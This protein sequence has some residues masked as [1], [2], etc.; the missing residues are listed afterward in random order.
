[1]SL[2]E[3]DY[4]K[5]NFITPQ[6][7]NELKALINIE[8]IGKNRREQDFIITND[9]SKNTLITAE[10]MENLIQALN[11]INNKFEHIIKNETLITAWK[12]LFQW[13]ESL[14]IL[15]PIK[16]EHKYDNYAGCDGACRG[17]CSGC[18]G[19]CTSCTGCTGSCEG[20]TS[21]S[22]C[23]GSC[24]GCSGCGGCGGCGG[25]SG[26][27]TSCS[28]CSGFS[29]SCAPGNNGTWVPNWG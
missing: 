15:Y 10:N 8:V 1:M 2:I 14:R 20:C 21:C 7:F 9:V 6:H 25:C 11:K 17:L 26:G 28:G 22:G 24:S 3:N 4:E 16:Q 12:I 29:Y 13:V 19:G 18:Y 23:S 27:C 5:N